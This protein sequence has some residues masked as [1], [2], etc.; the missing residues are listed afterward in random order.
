MEYRTMDDRLGIKTSL[1]GFGCMRLPRLENGEIDEAKAEEMLDYAIAHGVNYID[2][3][4]PYHGGKS[5]PFVGKVL[6]KYDRD[7]FY[8]ATKMPVWELKT[9]ED[10]PRIFAE[11]LERLKV[12]YIDF[13]LL[14]AMSRKRWAQIAD[15]GVL[16]FISEMKKAGKIK[17]LG[18]SFHDDYDA[19]E[20]IL[21]SFDWDFCQIQYNYMDCH[22]QAGDKGVALAET[23]GIPLV[24]MEP[25]KGG[26]LA[27][28]PD[29]I[30]KIYQEVDPDRSMASWALG[31]VASHQQVKVILSGMST[32]EQVKD[33][34]ATFSKDRIVLN[35]QE[36]QAVDAVREAIAA[37]VKNGCTG[38]AYC[39]PC[40]FGVNIP[41]NF[42]IWNQEAMY[43]NL[44]AAKRRYAALNE[45]QAQNCRKCGACEKVCPQHLSIRDNLV[46]VHEDLG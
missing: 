32:L 14:H 11:Q 16:D 25:V 5:E 15:L 24:V 18:F 43:G 19:F 44:A 9:K 36:L 10:A 20:M 45:G 46:R 39:M 8:L 1:L 7:R 31:W 30:A 29:D 17:H 38:C 26:S 4:Y 41:G 34:I 33:N 37:R 21:K 12:D 28:L 35:E 40:P 2:T 3:A 27:T 42:A 13:Y 22:E 6:S 23:M